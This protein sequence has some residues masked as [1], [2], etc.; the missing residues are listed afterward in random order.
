MT[1]STL[2]EV[3]NVINQATA[4]YGSAHILKWGWMWDKNHY[5]Y[6]QQSLVFTRQAQSSD[7]PEASIDTKTTE[8][9][10]NASEAELVRTAKTFRQ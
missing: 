8:S 4:G 10:E 3:R 9:T 1:K 7:L 5:L 2:T 6:I